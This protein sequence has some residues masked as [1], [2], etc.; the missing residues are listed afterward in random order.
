MG[1]LV[2]TTRLGGRTTSKKV[3]RKACFFPCT[4][5]FPSLQFSTHHLGSTKPTTTPTAQK[6]AST[7]SLAETPSSDAP[8]LP[9]AQPAAPVSGLAYHMS[10]RPTSMATNGLKRPLGLTGP[11]SDF[12]AQ[13]GESVSC[14]GVYGVC[15][16]IGCSCPLARR[17]ESARGAKAGMRTCAKEGQQARGVSS[18]TPS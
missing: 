7:A 5:F 3:T 1:H 10:F 13:P 15:V 18:P 17:C 2:M 8:L 12:L 6:K 11:A 16:H 9:Q 14:A 4:P